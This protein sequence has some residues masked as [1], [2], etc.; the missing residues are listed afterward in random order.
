MIQPAA[1]VPGA[2]AGQRPSRRAHY[3]ILYPLAARP[4]LLIEGYTYEVLDISEGGLR[5]RTGPHAAPNIGESFRG[6]VRVRR[7]E[8]I[9]THGNVVRHANGEVAA[10]LVVGIPFQTIMEE[11]RY[12]FEQ[13]AG[14]DA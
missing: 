14:L 3:R 12:V 1:N 10:R 4:K 13:A 7:G 8:M 6:T 5:Y 11:Q 2:P 9:H